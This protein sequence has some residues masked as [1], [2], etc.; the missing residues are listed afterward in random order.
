[1][2]ERPIFRRFLLTYSRY[3]RRNRQNLY[4]LSHRFAIEHL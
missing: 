1:V 4:S 3:A 2:G